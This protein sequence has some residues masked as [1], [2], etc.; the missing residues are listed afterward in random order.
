MNDSIVTFGNQSW[1]YAIWD[2]IRQRAHAFDGA[3]AWA[4]PRFNLAQGGEQSPVTSLSRQS[5]SPS[6][7]LCR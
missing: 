6:P 1:T 4:S 5:Q 2:N 7:V 3:F